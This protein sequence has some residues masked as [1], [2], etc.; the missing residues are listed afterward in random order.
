MLGLFIMKQMKGLSI[1]A[2]IS[3]IYWGLFPHD[4][5]NSGYF[6]MAGVLLR[7][8]M[9]ASDTLEACFIHILRQ[10]SFKATLL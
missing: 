7:D 3:S 5:F 1:M 6:S 10:R 2:P 9:H 4:E 8:I